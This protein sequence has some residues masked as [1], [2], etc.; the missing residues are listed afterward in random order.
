MIMIFFN[1]LFYKINI[2]LNNFLN[3]YIPNFSNIFNKSIVFS[4]SPVFNIYT[5]F[6][7][8]GYLYIGNNVII[9]KNTEIGKNSIVGAGSIVSGK[10]PD[11]VIIGGVPA[12][13]IKKIKNIE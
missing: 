9:P 12:K 6:R 7:G 8:N 13:I 1:K 11:N 10:F 2:T 3:Y 4:K 5:K